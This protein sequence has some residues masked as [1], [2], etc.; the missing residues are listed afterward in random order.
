VRYGIAAVALI[1]IVAAVAVSKSRDLAV[2]GD[3][4]VD[5][6]EPLDDDELAATPEEEALV[7]GA[8]DE[9]ALARGQAQANE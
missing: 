9:A 1:I 8:E 4:D 7:T 3:E 6:A 5:E 2:G